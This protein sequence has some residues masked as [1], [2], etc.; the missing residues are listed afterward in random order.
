MIK[1]I[2]S[3]PSLTAFFDRLDL[4][5]AP[6]APVEAVDQCRR[7]KE[8]A[9]GLAQWPLPGGQL[10]TKVLTLT[11]LR[12][13]DLDVTGFQS[14]P[15][16]LISLTALE[17]IYLTGNALEEF[18]PVLLQMTGLTDINM[19][20]QNPRLR[21][22]PDGISQLSNLKVLNLSGNNLQQLPPSFWMLERLENIYL[23]SNHII[24]LPESIGKLTK[25]KV[26]AILLI[27]LLC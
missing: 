18:P 25:L 26:C 22:V 7:K 2:I 11:H 16:G 15:D 8:D 10:P 21:S 4:D 1:I 17:R 9:L 23:D 27:D 5:K 20:L 3:Y 13:L 14:L 6:L 24:S 19:S 12:E